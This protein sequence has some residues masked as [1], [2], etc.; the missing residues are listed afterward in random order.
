MPKEYKVTLAGVELNLTKD[1]MKSVLTDS[2]FKLAQKVIHQ[3]GEVSLGINSINPEL[4]K[5]L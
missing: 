2:G 4:R 3:G 5:Q 1:E